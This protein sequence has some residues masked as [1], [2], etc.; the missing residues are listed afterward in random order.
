MAPTEVSKDRR[1]LH[2][3]VIIQNDA[4]GDRV[5]AEN[6]AMVVDGMD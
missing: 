6:I 1:L 2:R 4:N 5:L 3:N